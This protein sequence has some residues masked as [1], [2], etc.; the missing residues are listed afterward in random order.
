MIVSFIQELKYKTIKNI[1]FFFLV[2]SFF[3][4]ET[5]EFLWYEVVNKFIFENCYYKKQ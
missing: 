5:N 1:I 2:T 4:S 3:Q